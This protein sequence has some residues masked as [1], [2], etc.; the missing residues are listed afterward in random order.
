MLRLNASH[1]W[2]AWKYFECQF[3]VTLRQRKHTKM[4][5][6][7]RVGGKHHTYIRFKPSAAI[8]HKE[9]LIDG[10]DETFRRVLFLTRLTADRLAIFREAIARLIGLSGNQYAI[11]LAIANAPGEEGVTVR[12]VA[13]YTLMASTH[14]T[15]QVGALIRKKLV[16]KKPN[17]QDGRSVLVSL[18]AKG[19]QAVKHIAPLRREFNNAFFVG[20]SRTSLLAAE[21]FLEKVATN[22]DR[23][24]PLLKRAAEFVGPSQISKRTTTLGGN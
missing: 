1:L 6:R 20:V 5:Q 14:V 9:M 23:A 4:Q 18:T 21:D 15:T 2:L 3:L 12:D 13:R 24:M 22:S 17:D 10:T 16:C 11:L 7:L 8:S 19:E